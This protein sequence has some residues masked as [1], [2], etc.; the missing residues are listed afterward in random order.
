VKRI[1]F[2]VLGI[3]AFTSVTSHVE[4]DKIEIYQD[5]NGDGRGNEDDAPAIMELTFRAGEKGL[6]GEPVFAVSDVSWTAT[7]SDSWLTFTDVSEENGIE[8]GYRILPEVNTGTPRTGT[9]TFSGG[10]AT[11]IL[12]VHQSGITGDFEIL[13]DAILGYLGAGGDVVIPEGI[14]TIGY[15]AFDGRDDLRSV[16]FPSTLV[17]IDAYAF[18]NCEG[19]TSV[20]FPPSLVAIGNT[21]FFGTGLSTVSIPST[22]TSVGAVA[23]GGEKLT[24]VNVVPNHP[25][26]SSV[27]GVLFDKEKS[28][29]ILY[30]GGKTAEFYT[31]PS[32][33]TRI[34]SGAFAFNTRLTSLSLP[35]SL[36]DIGEMAF[37]WCT[38]LTSI[39]LPASLTSIRK[40]VFAGCEDLESITIPASVG[41]IEDYAFEDCI[42]LT[43]LYVNATMPPNTGEDVFYDVNTSTC[44]LYVPTGT[45]AAYRTAETWKDFENI[46]EHDPTG[47]TFPAAQNVFISSFNGVMTVNSPVAEQIDV[48]SANG[49]LLLRVQKTVDVATFNFNRQNRGVLIVK[50][51]SGWTKKII[52]NFTN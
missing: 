35:A 42:G 48:Y 25:I 5:L 22:L 23:F 34:E 14:T 16:T 51:S 39:D 50:G 36:T 31:I 37:A 40:S 27:D 7:C 45:K 12:T 33:V 11:K 44:T 28:V 30:P 29:L 43:S 24:A 21:A 26:Y 46:T 9:I 13:D 2:L 20:D 17:F 49:A 15:A 41:N 19:I 47:I 8:G 38:G 6:Y 10:E 1:V 4:A 32:S 52:N 18:A 3:L